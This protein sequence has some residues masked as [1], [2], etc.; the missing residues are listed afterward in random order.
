MN[1]GRNDPCPCGS[2][3]KYKRCCL[4]A[5]A[6]AEIESTDL[7]FRRV[8][9]MVE[10]LQSTMV[11]FIEDVY[12]SEA[13]HEAWDEFT[14]WDA[15]PEAFLESPHPQLF[16]AWF[17]HRWHPDPEDTLIEDTSVH[18]VSPTQLFLQRKGQRLDPLLRRYLQACVEA[19]FTFY[20]ILHAESGQLMRLRD[21]FTGTESHV[22][23]G[24]GVS[25]T[26]AGNILFAQLVPIDG[27]VVI[28]ASSPYAFRPVNKIPLIELRQHITRDTGS[29]P[30]H[31]ALIEWD[32]ALRE[33]YLR[34][35]DELMNPARPVIYNVDGEKVHPYRVTFGIDSAQVAFD[36]LNDLCGK[37]SEQELLREAQRGPDGE[38]RFVQ[39]DWTR[40][41]S[42]NDSN[43]DTIFLA[44]IEIFP[45]SI[46]AEVNSAERAEKLKQV[47]TERLGEHA[48]YESTESTLL[49]DDE[50]D[51]NDE[52]GFE[53]E[54]LL[55]DEYGEEDEDLLDAED[56]GAPKVQLDSED[57][58]GLKEILDDERRSCVPQMAKLTAKLNEI[59]TSYYDNWVSEQLPALGGRTPQE[60]VNDP[61]GREMVE[62][63][64]LDIEIAGRDMEPPL[65]ASI[66]R[67]MRERL[68][69]APRA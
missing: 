67:R 49:E 6:P 57:I 50:E 12:G 29:S 27:V 35:L 37:R 3:K 54:D 26:D 41:S 51:G 1:V 11:R 34:M 61:D 30:T 2:G 58:A 25:T 24:N 19:P 23:G 21:I 10:G 42:S 43:W 55:D 45:D 16:L 63:L 60:M 56:E 59:M 9:R 22:L 36:A 5:S 17:F 40:P 66:P 68:G 52:Y 13:A 47:I 31:S 28:E 38:L 62:A 65:D 8:R 20:D 44:S 4:A 48:R 33:Q 15:S 39:L 53:G 18:G 32:M 46:V 69:L 7:T 64:I 14:L